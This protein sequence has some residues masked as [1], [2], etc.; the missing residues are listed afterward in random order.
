MSFGPCMCGDTAC[1]SC[2]PAQGHDPDFDLVCEWLEE[3]I[4]ADMSA[5][6]DVSWWAEELANRIGRSAP[7]DVV[8]AVVAAAKLWDIGDRK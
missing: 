1:P 3:V 5:G 8:D 4:L 7:Q 6:H 2:G